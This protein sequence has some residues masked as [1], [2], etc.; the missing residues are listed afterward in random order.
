MKKF[1]LPLIA[2]VMLLAGCSEKARVITSYYT[3]QPNKWQLATAV[4]GSG[5]LYVDYAYSTWE[6]IDITPEVI[7][8]GVV[9]VYM[10]DQDGRDNLLPYTFYFTDPTGKNYQERFEFDV[11]TGLITFKFK[12]S[13]FN[14]TQSLQN[15]GTLEFKVSVIGNF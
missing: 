15:I 12:D 10:I 7:D 11:Q 5:N 4:D 8:N 14:T 9:L 1:L 3:V 2:L 6:N 13:D